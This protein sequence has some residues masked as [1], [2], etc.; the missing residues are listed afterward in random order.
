MARNDSSGKSGASLLL[1]VVG[2]MIAFISISN[3]IAFHLTYD[4]NV[5]T[6]LIKAEKNLRQKN[7]QS[8]DIE[9]TKK[10]FES[11]LT[12]ITKNNFPN[13]T[14]DVVSNQDSSHPI[15]G[16]SCSDHGGP[17]D[18]LAEEMIFWSDIESDSKYRSPFY[19]PEKYVT[20]E[21][22]H[23]G[24]NNIRMAMETVLVLAHAMGRTLVLP[25]EQGMYLL[26]KGK[27]EH[28]KEFSFNDFFHLD[29]ISIEHDGFNII[30]MEEFLK[31]KGVTDQLISHKTN[32]PLKPPGG[33]T[34]WNGQKLNQ[35]WTY[36]RDVGKSPN[37]WDPWGCIAAIPSAPGSKYVTEL[38]DMMNGIN[39]LKYGKI[40]DNT[41]AG[42]Y[43]NNPTAV[44]APTV[45]RLREMM[46]SRTK[47][48]IYDE[49]LQNEELIHF[50]VGGEDKAR[51]LTHF[52]AFVFFQDWVRRQFLRKNILICI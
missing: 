13:K 51:L 19:D 22:D 49:E 42:E 31:R 4:S 44:D 5:Q 6:E 11:V 48:C 20:F 45:D 21:P 46:A 40:P 38:K 30:T 50:K 32:Q 33:K 15:A 26:G 8:K 28:K 29:S 16:L 27:E 12:A 9:S 52:Y 36:L 39:D 34:D 43:V 10:D 17:S 7:E 18:G 41:V 23:G 1:Y 25:P 14:M 3:I 24:W 2:G 37:N 35:L 47:L